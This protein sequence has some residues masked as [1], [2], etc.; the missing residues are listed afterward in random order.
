MERLQ[1]H[2]DGSY[3]ISSYEP[4]GHEGAELSALPCYIDGVYDMP[5]NSLESHQKREQCLI[6]KHIVSLLPYG[7]CKSLSH[8]HSQD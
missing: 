8:H 4:H 1:E 5:I 3:E 6:M 7:V 2:C